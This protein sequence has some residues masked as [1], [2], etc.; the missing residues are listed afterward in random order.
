MPSGLVIRPTHFLQLRNLLRNLA[1]K[2]K[3]LFFEPPYGSFVGVICRES[4]KYNVP[5]S[6]S[7][8][9]LRLHEQRVAVLRL[10]TQHDMDLQILLLWLVVMVYNYYY[11]HDFFLSQ[12]LSRPPHSCNFCILFCHFC[13]T[14]WDFATG[15]FPQYCADSTTMATPTVNKI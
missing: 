2:L 14:V 10:D 7:G 12:Q 6:L 1:D 4:S 5:S 3:G 13:R 9:S 11:K 15:L 8:S